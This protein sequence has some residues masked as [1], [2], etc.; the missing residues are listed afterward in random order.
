MATEFGPKTAI[1]LMLAAGVG[2][3][4]GVAL[5][6]PDRSARLAAERPP[7]ELPPHPCTLAPDE[8]PH[9]VFLHPN[10]VGEAQIT[11][12][13]INPETHAVQRDVTVVNC[14]ASQLSEVWAA[15]E[16]VWRKAACQ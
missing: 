13:K 5:P 16:P 3:S 12:L 15:C 1:A 9:A 2:A 10:D 4:I 8:V 6:V 11:H 14:K 7:V